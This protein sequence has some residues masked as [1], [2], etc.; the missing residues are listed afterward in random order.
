MIIKKEQVVTIHYTLK[1]KEGTIID[2]SKGEQPLTYIQGIGNI[3][4]GLE[5]QLEGKKVGENIDAVIEPKD[6]Y[7]EIIKEMIQIVPKSGFE[8]DDELQEGIQ[9]QVET[10]NGAIIARVVKIDGDDVTLDLNHPLAGET[11]FFNVDVVDIRPA[12]TEELDH[13][14]VHGP[15]G[16]HH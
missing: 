8:G 6:G 11:L 13:G 4:A 2:S 16:H 12:T 14:H 3:I 7:G 5:T 15:G 1:D 10:D 9:V